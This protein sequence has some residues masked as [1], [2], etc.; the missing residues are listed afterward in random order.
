M[1]EK[2]NINQMDLKKN[3][4]SLLI[5]STFRWIYILKAHTYIMNVHHGTFFPLSQ[6]HFM[7]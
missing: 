7:L 1:E 2:R 4:L 5:A 6:I 3:Y